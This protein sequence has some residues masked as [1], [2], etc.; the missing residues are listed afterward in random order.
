MKWV[1]IMK[2]TEDGNELMLLESP[3]ST[4]K[5]RSKLFPLWVSGPTIM[6]VLKYLFL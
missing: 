1:L 4:E 3:Y 5:K 6:A 2:E